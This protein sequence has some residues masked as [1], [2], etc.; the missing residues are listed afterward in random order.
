MK[1]SGM[2]LVPA[3]LVIG[4][5]IGYYGPS[6]KLCAY[7][8]KAA[9]ERAE[10]TEATKTPS[11]VGFDSFAEI[12]KIP[13][14]AKG[15]P[16]GGR[17]TGRGP[18]APA[19]TNAVAGAEA[20]GV[21]EAPKAERPKFNPEDLKARID[22]AADL[23]RTRTELK[24]AATIEKFKLDEEGAADFDRAVADM[25]DKLRE[26]IQSLADQVSDVDE[27]TPELGVRLMGD[28]S[29]TVAEAYDAVGAV[30]D[31][32]RRGEVSNLQLMEFVDPSV[33]EPLIGVQQKIRR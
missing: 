27:M 25:N 29:T 33:A 19:D 23:W 28:L 21:S 7:K 1:I 10:R 20:G 12:V 5:L 9:E 14:A 24:R 6:E 31:E 32:D 18:S 22:E 13:K 4:G 15:I 8:E 11:A 16:D 30:V 2:T 17:K 3:A 26:S